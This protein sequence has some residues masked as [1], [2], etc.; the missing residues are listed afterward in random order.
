MLTPTEDR[1]IVVPDEAERMSKGG[2]VIP[3]IAKEKPAKG[4]IVAVG[5]GRTFEN[6]LLVPLQFTVGQKVMFRRYGGS[7]FEVEGKTYRILE[8]VDVLATF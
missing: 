3:D 1:V 5:P 4:T 8:R 7:D 2:I 6:G